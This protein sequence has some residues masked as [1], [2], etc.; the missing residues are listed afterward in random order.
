MSSRVRAGNTANART[1]HTEH[2]ADV[3]F[4]GSVAA[5]ARKP[6]ELTEVRTESGVL[7]FPQ[8]VWTTETRH[9]RRWTRG[10]FTTGPWQ[11]CR[12]CRGGTRWH[13]SLA[14]DRRRQCE[15]PTAGGTV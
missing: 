11:T 2:A 10:R 4:V 9:A 13:T 12:R 15:S 1:K 6:D 3:G 8:H 5:F 7:A 14:G